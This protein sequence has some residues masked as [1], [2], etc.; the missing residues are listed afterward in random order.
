MLRGAEPEEGLAVR[1]R[2]AVK[3]E[4]LLRLYNIRRL[5][6]RELRGSRQTNGCCPSLR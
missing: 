4:L 5:R 2:V 6:G 1:E 3:Q